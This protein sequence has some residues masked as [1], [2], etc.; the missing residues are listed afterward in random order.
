VLV[1]APTAVGWSRWRAID[2]QYGFGMLRAA[3]AAESEA[4]RLEV[5]LVD[6]YAHML[7]ASLME[8]GLV[9]A[10]AEDPAEEQRRARLAVEGLLGRLLD[11]DLHAVAVSGAPAPPVR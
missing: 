2:A 5:E 7:L 9:I 4:G 6:P 3:L 10:A 1:D 8:L 11:D